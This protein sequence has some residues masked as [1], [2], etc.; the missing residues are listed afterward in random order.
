MSLVFA[1]IENLDEDLV[2]IYLTCLLNLSED[3]PCVVAHTVVQG[4]HRIH[5]ALMICKLFRLDIGN[6]HRNEVLPDHFLELFRWDTD[7]NTENVGQFV[8]D[9]GSDP[10][11]PA[12]F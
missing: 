7:Q 6:H 9:I 12:E 5:N 11:D 2:D 3:L 4:D 10:V 8:D 1:L